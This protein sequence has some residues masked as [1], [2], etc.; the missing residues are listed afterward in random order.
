MPLVYVQRYGGNVLVSG[1][2]QAVSGN[3]Q[4]SGPTVIE[5]D[6]TIFTQAGTYVLFTL[7]TFVYSPYANEQAALN[8]LVTVDAT[9]TGFTV[10]TTPT[11]TNGVVY[12]SLNNRITV[13]LA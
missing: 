12:D 8:A 5:L 11:A 10:V 2:T 9:A 13:T 6:P 3:L 7:G 4:F 1:G